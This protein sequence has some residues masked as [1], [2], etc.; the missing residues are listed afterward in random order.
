[1]SYK[2]RGVKRGKV[3]GIRGS[4]IRVLVLA[5][6][7][8]ELLAGAAGSLSAPG[9]TLQTLSAGRFHTCAV[10]SAAGAKCWGF[11]QKGQV[12]DGSVI[13]RHAPVDVQG[14]TSGVAAIAAGDHQP[15]GLESSGG[16]RVE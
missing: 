11:N 4:A 14:L 13:D 5:A 1:M 12:G 6:L 9:L 15:F 2:S 16:A 3:R 10:T 7:A 8:A